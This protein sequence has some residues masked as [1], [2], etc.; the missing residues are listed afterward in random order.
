M[1]S[2]ETRSP[3]YPQIGLSRCLDLAKALYEGIHR[4]SVGN[5]EAQQI[6]GFSPK[7]GSGLAA[8]S[9][10][11]RFGLLEGRDPQIRLT[12]LS[13]K[14]LEPMNA[15]E[16][17][18]AIAEAAR[19]P[20]LFAEVLDSFGGKI[21]AD[22]AIRARLVR[23]KGFTSAGS[24]AFIRSFK[25][26]FSYAER[27]AAQETEDLHGDDTRELASAAIPAGSRLEANVSPPPPT[28]TATETMVLRLS[29]EATVTI[30]FQ[31]RITQQ[32]VTKLSRLLEVLSEGY[33][34]E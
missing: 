33:A 23:D 30:S 5:S 8:L 12:D 7:S 18:K 13:M 21:P 34:P 17:S 3:T 6:M 20:T 26:T 15:D 2:G 9:A 32:G 27:E 1:A 22:S 25:D 4:A 14:I 29:P 16:R 31:G 10:L 28:T 11:K 24:D 19:H